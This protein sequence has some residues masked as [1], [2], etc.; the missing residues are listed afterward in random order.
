MEPGPP[1]LRAWSPSHWT[2]RQVPISVV[3][4]HWVCGTFLRQPSVQFSSVQ[5]LANSYHHQFLSEPNSKRESSA[6]ILPHSIPPSNKNSLD[7]PVLPSLS[8]LKTHRIKGS[9]ETSAI[10]LVKGP[11][12]CLRSTVSTIPWYWTQYLALTIPKD[13]VQAWEVGFLW[14]EWGRHR[15]V[16][17]HLATSSGKATLKCLAAPGCPA[18]RQEWSPAEGAGR[19]AG[20]PVP[21]PPELTLVLFKAVSCAWSFSSIRPWHLT[22]DWPKVSLDLFSYCLMEKPEWKLLAN[23]VFAIW[24]FNSN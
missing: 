14:E 5:S 12:F 1:A 17:K 19:L 3:L 16:W 23:P 20:T 24:T 11:A 18:G 10:S 22:L 15:G 8:T 2:T 7:L 4:S 9:R 21:C 13:S 6:K